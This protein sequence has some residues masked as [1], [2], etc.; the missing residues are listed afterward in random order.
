M[1]GV[2]TIAFL[3]VMALFTVGNMLLKMRRAS[4]PTDAHASW[5]VVIIAFVAVMA[6]LL[7]NIVSR[8]VKALQGF[9][10]F[11]AVFVLPALLMLNR[12]QILRIVESAVTP[13]ANR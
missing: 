13:W 11:G 7:G 6:G 3:S 10:I 4:L 12:S 9:F 5:K 2:Y 8:D 1:A